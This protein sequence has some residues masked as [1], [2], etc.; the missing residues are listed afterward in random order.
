MTN[1]RRNDENLLLTT[2]G[3]VCS[4]RH[5]SNPRAFHESAHSPDFRKKKKKKKVRE[6][7]PSGFFDFVDKSSDPA[8]SEARL[9]IGSSNWNAPWRDKSAPH[10]LRTEKK[11]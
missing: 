3:C 9:K 4:F 7:E 1:L 8:A 10:D 6:T 5:F 11:K 2:A